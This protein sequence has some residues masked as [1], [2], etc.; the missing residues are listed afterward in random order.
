VNRRESAVNG[1]TQSFA[2]EVFAGTLEETYLKKSMD[3]DM[4][5]S[6]KNNTTLKFKYV[7]VSRPLVY[8]LQNDSDFMGDL[9][10]MGFTKVIFTDGYYHTWTI[11]VN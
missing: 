8:Q 7:L 4:S 3:V 1:Y 10:R 11:D 5:V 2:R 6:G 9:R